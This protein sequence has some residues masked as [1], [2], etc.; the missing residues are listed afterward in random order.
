MTTVSGGLFDGMDTAQLQ[1]ALTKAQQAYIDLSTGSKGE[2]FSYAQGDGQKSVTY[3]RA[4][5]GQLIQLI[6]QL[7]AALGLEC[8]PRRPMRPVFR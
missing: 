4:S 3:T 5:V 2:S 1:A 8:R 7:K 6:N